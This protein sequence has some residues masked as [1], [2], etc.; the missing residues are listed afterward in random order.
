EV[1]SLCLHD[2]LP[3]W[4]RRKEP[5]VKLKRRVLATLA[6][7]AIGLG[8]GLAVNVL[9]P[10]PANAHGATMV[11]G[12]RQFLCW[13]HGINSGAGGDIQRSEEHTSELQSRAN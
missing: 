4:S 9:T 6:A 5:L 2:A 7:A 11:P 3:I 8:G 12:S 10:N 13:A 1:S